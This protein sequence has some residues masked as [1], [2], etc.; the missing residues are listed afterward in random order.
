MGAACNRGASREVRV[1]GTPGAEGMLRTG[2]GTRRILLLR[3][4]PHS[5]A[6]PVR[7]LPQGVDSRLRNLSKDRNLIAITYA[8]YAVFLVH[9]RCHD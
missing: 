1:V 5:P 9:T 4:L 6:V 2:T 3:P 8:R 7:T